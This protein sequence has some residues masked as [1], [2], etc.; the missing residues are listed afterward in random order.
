MKH[1]RLLLGAALALTSAWAIA[2]DSPESLLPPGFDRPA[3][4]AATPRAAQPAAPAAG[5][6]I[7]RPRSRRS[8]KESPAG[9]PISRFA[10]PSISLLVPFPT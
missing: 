7:L 8:F 1:V 2:Q 3:P 10:P 9:W 5:K 4:K 6:G